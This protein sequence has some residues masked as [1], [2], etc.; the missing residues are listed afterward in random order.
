MLCLRYAIVGFCWVLILLVVVLV[1][2]VVRVIMTMMVVVVAI[3]RRSITGTTQERSHRQ[4]VVELDI[5]SSSHI[6]ERWKLS[7]G[8]GK[9]ESMMLLML[10][11]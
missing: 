2:L 6:H 5:R 10:V 11:E 4:F 8:I 1:L 3:R 9:V 7:K